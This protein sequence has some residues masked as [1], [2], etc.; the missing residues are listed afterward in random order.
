MAMRRNERG[1]TLIEILIALF[2]ISVVTAA[3][4]K[5]FRAQQKSYMIQEEVVEMQ[6]NLRAGMEILTREIRMAGY[7]PTES[8]NFGFL[9]AGPSSISFTIDLNENGSVDSGS[10]P[11]DK[12][13]LQYQLSDYDGDGVAAEL[14]RTSGGAPVALNIE[15]IGFAYGYDT[16]P[17]GYL[18]QDAS[19]HII[20]AV[21]TNNDGRLDTNLDTNSDGLINASDNPAGVALTTPVNINTI[22]AVRIWMLART[23]REARKFRNTSTYVVGDQHITVNDGYRRRL[24]SAI[25]KCRNMG[26]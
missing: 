22:R 12:E 16:E 18:D 6:Q 11:S 2:L 7:D 3:I 13:T 4:Y 17:D 14:I 8:G 10:N 20:W 5:T 25:I 1:F 21:D 15:A 26:L 24:I 9:K 19:G 23:S